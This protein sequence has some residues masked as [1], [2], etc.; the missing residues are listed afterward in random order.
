MREP[1]TSGAVPT[2]TEIIYAALLLLGP[3]LVL[4]VL[5]IVGEALLTDRGSFDSA[6]NRDGSCNKP[7]VCQQDSFGR[8]RCLPNGAP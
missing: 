8:Y 2:F 4:I 3:V 6:C 5:F 1:I 7:L